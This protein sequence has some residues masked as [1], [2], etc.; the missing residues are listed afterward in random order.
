[1]D[2][3]NIEELI[4][5]DKQRKMLQAMRQKRWIEN[6]HEEYLQRKREYSKKYYDKKK[7]EKQSQEA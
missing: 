3:I 2:N 4:K 1:M 6:H 7:A 5:K